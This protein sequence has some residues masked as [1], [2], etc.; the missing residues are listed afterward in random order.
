[1][2]WDVCTDYLR[3]HMQEN[4]D[5]E[6][7]LL[8]E[9]VYAEVF[10]EMNGQPQCL[11]VAAAFARFV[12]EKPIV[13]HDYDL[14]AGTLQHYRMPE[15]QPILYDHRGYDLRN[16]P[17][18]HRRPDTERILRECSKEAERREEDA[19]EMKTL[20]E[21]IRCGLITLQPYG[22]AIG[23]F[24][25]VIR[26]GFD[27]VRA[28]IQAR[29]TDTSVTEEQMAQLRAMDMTA[30]ASARYMERCGEKAAEL[31]KVLRS[32]GGEESEQAL[33]N[34]ER[35][36]DSCQRIAHEPAAT[37]F[38]AVQFSI[39]LQEL[40]I[41]ETS[42]GSMSLGRMD[43][44]FYPLYAKDLQAGVIG[45]DEAQALIDAW[46]MKLAGLVQAFQNVAIG[47]CDREGKFAGNA[48]TLMI[49]RSAM[50]YR[51]DQ[52][53]LSLRTTKDMPEEF[54][55]TAMKL[56]S[57]GDGFPALHNDE[58][59]IPALKRVGVAEE[60][61]WNYG[62]VG[63]V[64][65]AIGGKE[66]S[67]TEEIRINWLKI[68]EVMLNG[69]ICP[70]TKM[71]VPLRERKDLKAIKSIEELTQW[72]ESELVFAIE[73]IAKRCTMVD[74][75]FG[76][77]FPSPYL[78]MT[79]EGC[80]EGACDVTG[81][82]GPVYRFSTINHCGMANVVDS[83]LAIKAI[84]FDHQMESLESFCEIL[85]RDFEG[86]EDLRLYAKN[87]TEHFGNDSEAAA[88][89]M[90]ELTDLAA[91]TV[92][93]I[94][95]GR[96]FR[97]RSG[98][99]SVSSHAVF[100]LY[101]GASADGRHR[102]ESLANGLSPVQGTDR[103]GPVAVIDAVSGLSH[104]RFGN[105]MVLDLKFLP[106]ILATEEKRKKLS[107]LVQTYFDRGGMEIQFNVVDRNTLLEAQ[108]QPEK[109]RNLIVRV[110]GFSAY[111]TALF[112]PLQDEIIARTEN[113][114]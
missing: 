68:L 50:K 10:A 42:S 33:C 45:E 14:L 41:I 82:D 106:S 113:G 52:P 27:K 87:K 51:F 53:L 16:F 58:V 92:D 80:A 15:S 65:P 85:L 49:L 39:L 57:L 90:K 64:E 110:S 36:A 25:R 69:G 114:L 30:E 108:K 79:M 18:S 34:L 20:S 99:Y 12:R 55:D 1:M 26:L 88:C 24:E 43:Q 22:H 9:T 111:F 8:R 102:S 60:D 44:I 91:E 5:E 2:R 17:T 96:G 63:C 109:Y 11:R 94:E 73:R 70:M 19:S 4:Y 13:L 47:G 89:L 35:I 66:F 67:N 105:G 21:D 78:S 62:I 93:S 107:A 76:S 3:E 95:N 56:I 72:F 28:Q 101:T 29:L 104:E 7:L 6:S 40:T 100:G 84:V 31:V 32:R 86:R 81:T 77:A 83:L 98:M 97:Y 59:I 23:G 46:R 75:Y 103:K 48:V 74:R 61:A 37:F 54:W 112:K 71:K 38:D